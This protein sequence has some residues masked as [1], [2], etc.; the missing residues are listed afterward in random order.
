MLDGYAKAGTLQ[1]F[2]EGTRHRAIAACA[3]LGLQTK[4][5]RASAT[6]L[7]HANEVPTEDEEEADDDNDSDAELELSNGSS[8]AKWDSDFELLA[9]KLS[10]HLRSI[11]KRTA[12]VSAN[13]ADEA[14]ASGALD[15]DDESIEDSDSA[16]ADEE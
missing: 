16:E 8:D 5:S 3:Q 11:H 12:A 4:L 2:E 13:P 7:A 14:T 6:E 15:E 10:M 9:D 1:I